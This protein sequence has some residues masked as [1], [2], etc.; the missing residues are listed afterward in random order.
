MHVS[1]YFLVMA[2]A[3][4]HHNYYF[5]CYV[6][7]ISDSMATKVSEGI[8]RLDTVH[9]M[10][11]IRRR[12]LAFE[13]K[14]YPMQM[15]GRLVY[16]LPQIPLIS[17]EDIGR[18]K[19]PPFRHHPHQSNRF[20][21]H[22]TELWCRV[23]E[24]Y[25]TEYELVEDVLLLWSDINLIVSLLWLN[26]EHPDIHNIVKKEGYQPPLDHKVVIEMQ[27]TST[28]Y[29][30]MKDHEA[31]ASK[32]VDHLLELNKHLELSRIA[33]QEADHVRKHYLVLLTLNE[34]A[35]KH[36]KNMYPSEAMRS[37]S[38]SALFGAKPKIKQD[39]NRQKQSADFPSVSELKES[40]LE[41]TK[42]KAKD[43][44]D[45]LETSEMPI[46]EDE[47]PEELLE[48]IDK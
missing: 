37:E 25:M 27:G 20:C 26:D 28:L 9:L 39:V 34:A 35:Y 23:A 16:E 36:E 45:E 33:S 15:A 18:V 21:S 31:L 10:W 13:K 48:I 46:L 6:P 40:L 38:P 5:L 7:E 1:P 47:I 3:L 8:E 29:E 14:G 22:I 30:W 11:R 42:H 41:E 2:P 24:E 44:V 17:L 12:I 19:H 4:H 32:R 43:W